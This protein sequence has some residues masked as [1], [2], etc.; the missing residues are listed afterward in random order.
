MSKTAD[1]L[2]E[3]A[4]RLELLGFK[5]NHNV[6]T[7]AL[8][9][10]LPRCSDGTLLLQFGTGT[11]MTMNSCHP[12]A[13]VNDEQW[14]HIQEIQELYQIKVYHVIRT[15]CGELGLMDAYLYISLPL[16][17]YECERDRSDIKDKC[18]FAY[19]HNITDPELSEFGSIG[20]EFQH[21]ALVRTA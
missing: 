17:D 10:E 9:G 19:V 11:T 14:K 3:A 1:V 21:H 6:V 8:A 13:K 5:R 12:V 2:I 15:D 7:D 16:T 4:E 20:V 18:P